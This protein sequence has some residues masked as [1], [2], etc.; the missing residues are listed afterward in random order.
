M[1]TQIVTSTL[2]TLSLTSEVGKD[3]LSLMGP[4]A[5]RAGT[6][7]MRWVTVVE[8]LSENSSEFTMGEV[9]ARIWRKKYAT[10]ILLAEKWGE[11]ES[12]SAKPC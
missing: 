10:R 5:A 7:R 11:M 9:S 4:V 1:Y 3:G 6:L 12:E 8:D 2:P